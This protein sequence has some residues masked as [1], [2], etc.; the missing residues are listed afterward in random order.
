MFLDESLFPRSEGHA[1]VSATV[2]IASSQG[3]RKQ[4]SVASY[5]SVEN[6]QKSL[7]KCQGDFC[8]NYEKTYIPNQQSRRI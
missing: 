1:V 7:C 2:V 8:V 6:S 4:K 5:K 3:L